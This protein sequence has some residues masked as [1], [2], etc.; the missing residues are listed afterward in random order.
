MDFVRQ[1]LRKIPKA[2]EARLQTD[3][4]CVFEF[5]EF[6]D[7]F[8]QLFHVNGLNIGLLRPH[9][10]P[11]PSFVTMYHNQDL[12]GGGILFLGSFFQVFVHSRKAYVRQPEWV[13]TVH[14][15][16]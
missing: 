16:I 12:A 1:V 6:L 14:R 9:L 5:G 2:R 10:D 3:G 8:R 7:L 4:L 13:K 15:I 11:R